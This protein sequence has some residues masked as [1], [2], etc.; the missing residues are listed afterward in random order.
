MAKPGKRQ[1]LH[2]Y[3]AETKCYGSGRVAYK[4]GQPVTLVL[5]SNGT[6]Y[7]YE[8]DNP[9]ETRTEEECVQRGIGLLYTYSPETPI[10]LDGKKL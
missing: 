10:E 3:A 8:R 6:S 2:V 9:R 1:V 7:V 5:G 4:Q